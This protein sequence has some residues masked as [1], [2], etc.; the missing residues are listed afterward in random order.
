M[1]S[2]AGEEEEVVGYGRLGE[3]GGGIWSM[4]GCEA[5]SDDDNNCGGVQSEAASKK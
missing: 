2:V 5:V 3:G 4:G 1:R